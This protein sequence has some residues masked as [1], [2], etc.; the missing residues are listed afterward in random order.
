MT[1][2]K[3]AGSVLFTAAA[4]VALVGLS[5]GPALAATSLTVKV[6][7][8]GSYKATAGTTILQDG[9][10]KVTC[11]SSH[12]SGK[13]ASGTYKG[14]APTKVGTTSSLSFSSCMSPA[15]TPTFKYNKLPYSVKANSKTVKGETAAIISGTNVTVT[16]TDCQFTVT[17]SAP[18][19]YKNSNHTLYITPKLPKGLKALTKARLTIED[20]STSAN[21]GGL[22][23]NGDHPTFTGTYKVNRKIKITSS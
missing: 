16:A 3:R 19:Y 2:R 17:G 15:G 5:V 8:G 11:S 7:G 1:M 20:V 4:T 14:K 21:C 6:S 23:K 22:V 10:A 18:G 13:L 12:A 9:I